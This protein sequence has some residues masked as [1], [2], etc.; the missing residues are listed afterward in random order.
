MINLDKLPEFTGITVYDRET[1]EVNDNIVVTGDGRLFEDYIH[2]ECGN[3]YEPCGKYV[4][5]VGTEMYR[6]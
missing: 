1:G 2:M 4:I 6:W 5:Q 3:E